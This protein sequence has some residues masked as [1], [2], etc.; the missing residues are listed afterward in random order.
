MSLGSLI[1]SLCDLRR[2]VCN[3]D[4]PSA[5]D[6]RGLPGNASGRGMAAPDRL[7]AR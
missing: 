7:L 3:T 6:R 4:S 5:T 2:V 1:M